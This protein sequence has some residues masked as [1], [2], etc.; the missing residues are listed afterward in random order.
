MTSEG[1]N[2]F[3]MVKRPLWSIRRTIHSAAA[4]TYN[5]GKIYQSIDSC[6]DLIVL[7]FFVAVEIRD[8]ENRVDEHEL[9]ICTIDGRRRRI[10]NKPVKTQ[11]TTLNSLARC[12]HATQIVIKKSKN[13]STRYINT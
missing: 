9:I 11:E 10:C 6:D 13:N 5:L 4:S 3:P 2:Q 8:P 12:P 1:S 7:W